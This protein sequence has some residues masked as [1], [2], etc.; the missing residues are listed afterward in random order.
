M[1]HEFNN[2]CRY[3]AGTVIRMFSEANWG[4]N[5][6]PDHPPLGFSKGET[7]FIIHARLVFGHAGYHN[8]HPLAAGRKQAPDA[9][10]V[11]RY[12]GRGWWQPPVI[13]ALPVS[14]Q[15]D[16]ERVV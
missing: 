15:H 1:H 14:P 3:L 7:T 4:D 12:S 2:L 9:G 5:I 10:Q 8:T 13:A 6:P 16:I 11:S